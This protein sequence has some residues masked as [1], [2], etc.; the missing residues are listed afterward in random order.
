MNH[1]IGI[2]D[3]VV[4][5]VADALVGTISYWVRGVAVRVD[6]DEGAAEVLFASAENPTGDTTEGIAEF[7]ARLDESSSSWLRHTTQHWIGHGFSEWPGRDARI[8]FMTRDPPG[9]RGMNQELEFANAAVI[10]IAG[11]LS[12][13]FGPEMWG[14]AFTSEAATRTVDVH[15]AFNRDLTRQDRFELEEFL[16]ALEV[17]DTSTLWRG[18]VWMGDVRD[19][20]DWPGYRLRRV[21]LQRSP[22]RPVPDDFEDF[23]DFELG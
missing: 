10:T 22:D 7:S 3:R 1:E 6:E 8:V 13:A 12:C 20:R 16:F 15:L 18:H 11:M 9:G 5:A 4:L 14:V 2:E 21:H 23:D 17:Q 19:F